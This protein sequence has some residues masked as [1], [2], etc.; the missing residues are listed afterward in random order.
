[1]NKI[2]VVGPYCS[3]KTLLAAD[4]AARAKLPLFDLEGH[5]RQIPGEAARFPD[6]VDSVTNAAKWIIVGNHLETLP[7]RLSRA[8]TV[9]LLDYR[10]IASVCRIALSALRWSRPVDVETRRTKTSIGERLWR[11]LNFRAIELPQIY[12]ALTC[13]AGSVVVLKSVSDKAAWLS[14]IAAEREAHSRG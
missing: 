7:L 10:T 1:M 8:D 4:L 5:K 11:A 2:I 13:F 6:E 14:S 3:A 9:V 12:G